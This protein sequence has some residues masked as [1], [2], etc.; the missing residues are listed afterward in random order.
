MISSTRSSRSISARIL[1]AVAFLI[2]LIFVLFSVYNDVRQQGVIRE[3]VE[4]SLA[5]VGKTTAD[6]VSSWL[7]GRLVLMTYFASSVAARTDGSD[8]SDLFQRKALTDTFDLIYYGDKDGGFGKFPKA[9]PSPAGYDPRVRPWYKQVVATGTIALTEPYIAA[10][11]QELVVTAAAPVQREGALAGVVGADFTI[12]TLQTMLSNIDLGGLGESFLVDGTGKILVH[13]QRELIGHPL[14]ALFPTDTP[15]VDL[16][17]HEVMAKDGNRLVTFI[18]I[19]GLPSVDWHLALSMD[20]DKAEAGLSDFRKSAVIATLIA[21]AL[22]IG[23]LRLLIG[24]IIARPLSTITASMND[25]AQGNLSG[26]L[27]QFDRTDEIGAMAKALTVFK[28]NAVERQEA[29]ERERAEERRLTERAAR[30]DGL[31]REFDVDIKRILETVA[32]AVSGLG[33]ASDALEKSALQASEQATSVA[34]ASE[35]ATANVKEVARNTEQL[36]GKAAEIGERVSQS[37]DIAARAMRQAESTNDKVQG[38]AD[39]VGQIGEVLQLINGI[40]SQTNLLALNATI[41]AAR[42]GEAGKGFA[43]VANEVKNLANQTAQAT[44]R[45]TT[46]IQSIQ[47]ETGEAVSAIQSIGETIGEINTISGDIASAVEEQSRATVEIGH[48]I[49]E[50]SSGTSEVTRHIVVVS[51]AATQTDGESRKVSKAALDLRNEADFLKRAVERFLDQVR[52]A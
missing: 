17:M 8:A 21:L 48:N 15:A 45:V 12:D 20:L 11:T 22:T 29:L 3:N 27:P 47:R 14:S 1:I 35:E 32:K 4:T 49:D 40:A 23:L 44:E 13:G 38:L 6:G 36:S 2:I 51:Q 26:P 41:E 37:S 50:A 46:Q 10:A 33:A 9:P 28:R 7:S 34:S 5:N 16:G 42:A 52:A 18:P 19:P 24:R 39:A 43:V 30:M 25:L 31:T